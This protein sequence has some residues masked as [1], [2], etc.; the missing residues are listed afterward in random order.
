MKRFRITESERNDILRQHRSLLINEQTISVPPPPP[1]AG[2]QQ[3][4]TQPQTQQPV[5]Q[6]QYTIKQLQ[7]LLNSRGYN[8]GTADGTFGK[9]T[10]AGL[11]AALNSIKTFQAS[12][13]AQRGAQAK[14]P[15]TQTQQQSV[16]K[17]VLPEPPVRQST[18]PEITSPTDTTQKT[19]QSKT[20]PD[21]SNHDVL[22]RLRYANK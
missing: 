12:V 19:S 15:T 4:T 1:P 10:L 14:L 22:N 3:V 17:P 21:Y 8:V 11:E 16:P 2:G 7:E 9:N 6:T 5:Q 18:E 20:T 13:D